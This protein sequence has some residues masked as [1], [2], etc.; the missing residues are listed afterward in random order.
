MFFVVTGFAPAWFADKTLFLLWLLMLYVLSI[1][2]A[3]V[4]RTEPQGPAEELAEVR[5]GRR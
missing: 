4:L 3:V 5:A 1:P 2:L